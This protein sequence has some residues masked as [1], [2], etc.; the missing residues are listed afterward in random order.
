MAE[1]L[2]LDPCASK[3]HNVPQFRMNAD[4]LVQVRR[5]RQFQFEARFHSR[6]VGGILGEPGGGQGSWLAAPPPTKST[7]L[8]RSFP[9]SLLL[10]SRHPALILFLEFRHSVFRGC[11]DAD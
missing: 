3:E 9:G 5:G 6:L 4:E 8:F 1:S 7:G 10:L 2:P 11:R